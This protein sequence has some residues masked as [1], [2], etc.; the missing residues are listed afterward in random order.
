MREGASVCVLG[1]LKRGGGGGEE[2]ESVSDGERDKK[3]GRG[4]KEEDESVQRSEMRNRT[5]E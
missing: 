1:C 3:A 5:R 4:G 2:R